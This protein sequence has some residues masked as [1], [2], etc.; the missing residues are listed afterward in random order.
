MPEWDAK[1]YG[2]RFAVAHEKIAGGD[3]YQLNLTFKVRFQLSGSPLALYRDLRLRQ[4]VAYGG[5]IDTGR[6]SI[7]SLSPELFFIRDGSRIESRPMK[8]TAPRGASIEADARA[9]EEL[10]SDIKQRA[11]NLMIVD[12]VRSDIGRTAVPGSV[13]VPA[14]CV[15]ESYQTVHQ[16]VST[17]RGKLLSGTSHGECIRG[18]FPGGSMTGAPKLRTMEILDELEQ[19]PRG[20]Y[21]GAIGYLSLEGTTDLSIAI[22]TIVIGPDGRASVGVGGAITALS[23]PDAELREI[24]LKARAQLLALGVAELG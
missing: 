14:R 24:K 19:G 9:R 13:T 11:E 20:I 10:S 5:F 16:L 7:L 23:D 3:I 4:P 21:S 6:Q 22:R 2:D 18:L 15:V 12:L 17:V 8:G 1:T